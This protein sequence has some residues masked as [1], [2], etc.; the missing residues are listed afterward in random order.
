MKTFISGCSFT[1][2]PAEPGSERNICWPAHLHHHL[3]SID[4]TNVA[5]PGAGNRYIADSVVQAICNQP[6]TYDMIL[7]MWSGVS[8]LDFLTNLTDPDWGDLYDDYGFYRRVDS[9]PNT[10]GYIFSGGQLGPWFRHAASTPL[11][12][13]MY[14][15]SDHLSL[16]Y[17]NLIE[18]VKCQEFIKSKNIPYKFMSYVNYWNDQTNLSPNGDFGVYAHPEVSHLIKSIDFENWI[19]LNDSKDGIYEMAKAADDYHGDRFHPGITTH[20]Q[21]A[22]IVADRLQPVYHRVHTDSSQSPS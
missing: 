9:C 3:S 19:F 6:D 4:I 1:H 8:R 16:A 7:V 14:K 21:W 11:F 2:W 18:I 17:Q 13:E 20:Q 15:V 12:R 10:L 22:K 5:E